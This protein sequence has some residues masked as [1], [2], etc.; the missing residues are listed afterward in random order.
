MVVLLHNG[1]I[2]VLSTMTIMSSFFIPFSVADWSPGMVCKTTQAG[3]H[4]E[5]S[6]KSRNKFH[7]T[8]CKPYGGAQY[9]V[10][11]QSGAL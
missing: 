9:F 3:R 1:R 2:I 8:T 6:S 5:E 4:A 10:Y 11:V 7:Q